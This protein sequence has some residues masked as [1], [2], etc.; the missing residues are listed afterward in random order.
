MTHLKENRVNILR[1]LDQKNDIES[2]L[3]RLP[4]LQE[5]AKQYQDLGID[6]KLKIIPLLEKEKHLRTRVKED[7][8]RVKNA[9]EVLRES[10]PDTVFLSDISLAE[11]PN[12]TV[13]QQKKKLLDELKQQG[14]VAA[15]V[16]EEALQK[17]TEILV[18]LHKS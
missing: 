3:E 5:Q 17:S 7:V 13:F 2:E 9:L 6:E 14:Q 15:S 11:L 12:A 18:P 4:K 10:L 16:L 1:V 8:E